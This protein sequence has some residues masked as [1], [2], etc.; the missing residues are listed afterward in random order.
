[1]NDSGSAVIVGCSTTSSSIG[2]RTSM[3][4]AIEA[5]STYARFRFGRN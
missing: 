1:M 4:A 5:L 2:T 3:P